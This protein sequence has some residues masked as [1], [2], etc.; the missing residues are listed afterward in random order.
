MK[1]EEHKSNLKYIMN[2]AKIALLRA[3]LERLNARDVEQMHKA[4]TRLIQV[5]REDGYIIEV[6]K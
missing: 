2:A 5:M 1:L 4:M 6:S 3:N